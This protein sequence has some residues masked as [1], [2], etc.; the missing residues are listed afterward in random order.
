MLHHDDVSIDDTIFYVRTGGNINELF[1]REKSWTSKNV[2][3]VTFSR[4]ALKI[5]DSFN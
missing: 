3:I 2:I 4:K 1:L 5:S